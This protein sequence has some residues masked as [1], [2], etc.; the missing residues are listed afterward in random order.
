MNFLRIEPALPEELASEFTEFWEETFETSYDGFQNMLDGHESTDNQDIIYV[1]RQGEQLV[2]TCH[3]TISRASPQLG[4]LG[5]VATAPEFRRQGIGSLLCEYAHNDFRRHGGEALFL[6]TVN[7]DA[8]RVYHRLGWRKLAGATV[9]ALIVQGDS[10]EAFLVDYFRKS[11]PVAIT[12]GGPAMRIPMIP[13]L[14]CPHDWQVLDANVAMFST[15]YVVQSSC[16]GLY[17]RYE[18][19]GRDEASA[20][21][22][23]HGDQ[24]RLVGLATARLDASGACQ[25][26]GFTHG[27]FLDAWADLMQAAMQW[28][29]AV[30]AMKWSA[31]I[32]IEDEDK[33]ARFE[34]L[35]FGAAGAGEEFTLAG[36]P[37]PSLRLERSVG[38]VNAGGN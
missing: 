26:D 8:A 5:E 13:L 9:M 37:V 35:G 24:E 19:L 20:W 14:V 25:V 36:R 12:D 10:P 34:S 33:R 21:F 23:M 28:G 1:M 27:R 7:P 16:M 18:A 15:R 2:G 30:G 32:S 38:N 6:G 11:G 22:G 17:P 31:T 4:G 29:A 3:L